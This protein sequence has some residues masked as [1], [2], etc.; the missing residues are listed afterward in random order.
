MVLYFFSQKRKIIFERLVFFFV[1]LTSLS[2]T[3]L[4]LIPRFGIRQ[5]ERPLGKT[6][7][8]EGD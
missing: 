4:Y 3:S 2:H 1:R 5:A 8:R 6:E 7:L